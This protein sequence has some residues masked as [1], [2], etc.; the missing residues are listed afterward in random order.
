VKAA[1]ANAAVVTETEEGGEV[2]FTLPSGHRV[3]GTING[4]GEVTRVET[5]VDNPVFGDMSVETTYSDYR[6]FEGIRFPTRIMQSQG[7]QPALDL[8]IRTVTPNPPASIA[9]PANVL[10]AAAAPVATTT[11]RVAP[12]VFYIRGG[13]HHSVAIEMM[14]HVVVV[15]GPQSEERARAV[16]EAVKAAIPNK[17]IRYVVNTHVHFDHSGGL[18]PFVAEGATVVTHES[19]RQFYEQAWAAPRTL[20]ADR[21][22]ESGAPP[23]FM[24]VGD[25]AELTDGRRTIEIHRIQDSPHAIGFLMVWLPAERIL[26]EADAFTPGARSSPFAT[27]L[28]AQ[29]QALRLPVTRIA[30]V[31][32][33]VA[34]Y[35]DLQRV[36]REMGAAARTQ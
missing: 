27:N 19:N 34:P 33:A 2:A 28:L 7:G 3:A 1:I 23:T 36:V 24:T 21:L 30:A 13:S 8:T 11:E 31:H 32:N 25:K 10:G 9:V 17:P 16:I 18:R 26:I 29:I 15:E 5:W 4:E 35:A 14:D 6:E 20:K 22:S 12:G